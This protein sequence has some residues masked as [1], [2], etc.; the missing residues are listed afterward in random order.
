MLYPKRLAF[1]FVLISLFF[2]CKK[3]VEETSE[4]PTPTDIHNL[5]VSPSFKFKTDR[6]VNLKLADKAVKKVKY[7][8][9]AVFD[10]ETSHL[11]ATGQPRN[12]K[13]EIDAV[14]PDYCDRV[15]VVRNENGK[16]TVKIL[17][18]LGTNILGS[19][20][21]SADSAGCSDKLYAVNGQGGFYTI[22]LDSGQYNPTTM[23]NLAGGG[24]IACAIDKANNKMY[25]NTG[26]TLRYY[27]LSTGTFHVAQT[28]NPFNGSY[29]RMEY[30]QTNG[31]LYI[32]KNE[33]MYTINPLNNSIV[34]TYNIVGLESPVGGGDVAISQ[35]GTIYMC[36]FS[37]LYKISIT[38]STANATRISAEQFPYSPTSM[39]I[40]RNDRLYMATNNSNSHLI[41]MDKNDGAWNIVRT[42]PHKINDLGSFKCAISELPNVDTDGDGVV[43][44][45]DDYPNDS[46]A[47]H[48]LYTPSDIGWGSLAFE[49][50]WPSK[51]DYDFND[52]VINYRFTKVANSNNEV[53][54]L[55]A[56]FKVKAI[57]ASFH[58]GFG[59]KT[60]IPPSLI[61]S[62]TGSNITDGLV[63]LDAKGLE[64]GHSS[65]STIIVFDDAFNN[66]P[67]P[68][69][70]W[71][72]NTQLDAPQVEGNE[73]EIIIQFVNPV[74]S[75]VIGNPPYNPFIFTRGDRGKEIHLADY[76]PT[77]LANQ[78]YFNTVH[79]NSSPSNSRYYRTANNLPWGINI[80]HEFRYPLEKVSVDKGYNHFNNWA[81]TNGVSYGNWYKDNSGYRNVSKLYIK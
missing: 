5:K 60:S 4:I 29:P 19:F 2:S 30:N 18:A 64:N 45:Q 51:G 1:S 81:S 71:F 65:G 36:C 14:I 38:G 53:V 73:I 22:D 11:I 23:P 28:G 49:D 62:V 43:D 77:E 50:L 68:G 58:N 40:D 42:Y 76:P 44:A 70:G 7:H 63:T 24:S 46:S 21:R 31:L 69:Q 41:E 25:Y 35:T 10:K 61:S 59:F 56:K 26:T 52:L 34:G 27:D 16:E 80:I 67:S 33:V 55:I 12:G 74:S 9:Y 72:V 48:N 79:D 3:N 8:V 78:S 75:A 13:F 39:A 57:G 17:P 32:A 6:A 37:G 20:K 66:I 15:K 54:R 47:A